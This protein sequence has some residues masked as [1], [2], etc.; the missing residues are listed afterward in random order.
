M[1]AT[2]L[3]LTLSGDPWAAV[4]RTVKVPAV[5]IVVAKPVQAKQEYKLHGGFWWYWGPNT[6]AW[7]WWDE[8]GNTWRQW[9]SRRALAPQ[10]SGPGC[11]Q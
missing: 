5:V 1:L 7:W 3:L 6:R 9:A 8:P 2:I 11:R 4:P 10:C